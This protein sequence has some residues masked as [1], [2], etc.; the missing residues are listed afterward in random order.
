MHVKRA[1]TAGFCMGVGL[2][3]KKLDRELD[4]NAKDIATLGPIIH[5]P[6][7]LR[8]YEQKGV[9]CYTDPAEARSGQ[10]V[11]I[12]AHGIP[13]ETESALAAAGVDLVDATCPKVKRAQLG[14]A[15]QR[16]KGRTLLL[17]GEHD[18]PEVQGLLSYAGE[19]AVVFGSLEELQNGPLEDDRHYFLAAQ[20]T[21]DKHAFTSVIEWVRRR[22]GDHVPV[23]DTIC[24][25]TRERQDEAIAIARSVDVMVVV[26]GFASG[27]TR[28]LAEVAQAQG[29]P[30]YHV[31]TPDQLPL[32]AIRG[33]GAAG[34]TA[35]ASTPKSIIDETQKL[36]ESL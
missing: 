8:R 6:Q 26:G 11:V 18:H 32:D 17:F 1:A 19:G 16:E 12:R 25:A 4:N 7:V 35:G 22:F 28:R 20:T 5:N 31:E 14:I 27:N 33:Y 9:R 30:T 10:R 2:A 29:V 3:L 15:R 36:L 34:L 21:Q 24:D 13:E 23:L